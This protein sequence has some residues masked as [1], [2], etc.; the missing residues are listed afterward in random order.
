MSPCTLC[1]CADWIKS[2]SSKE[3]DFFKIWN[4]F[5]I[6]K[7]SPKFH[8]KWGRIS[9]PKNT[10]S[11]PDWRNLLRS[12][13]QTWLQSSREV[14][15]LE[16]SQ[17]TGGQQMLQPFLRKGR[18]SRPVTTGL[19][20]SPVYAVRYRNMWSQLIS[21]NTWKTITFWQTAARMDSEQEGA[22]K[23]NCWH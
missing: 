4:F 7:K 8:W 12:Y 9:S 22:L 20:L 13:N 15:I 3:K 10:K 11:I 23:N 16:S 14:S 21:W 19:F 5:K 2:Q 6:G 18:S 17:K 1:V